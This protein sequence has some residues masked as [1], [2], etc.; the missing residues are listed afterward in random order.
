MACLG[1][2]RGTKRNRDD[3]RFVPRRLGGSLGEVDREN[4]LQSIRC[5]NELQAEFGN[6]NAC[7]LLLRM[8]NGE[9]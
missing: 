7:L 1:R 2:L 3:R 4:I 5:F 8:V 9:W 6:I